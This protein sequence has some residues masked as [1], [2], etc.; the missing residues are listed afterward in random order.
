MN[1]KKIL[2]NQGLIPKA[3][4]ANEMQIFGFFSLWFVLASIIYFS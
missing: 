2:K 3:S 1:T 4:Q